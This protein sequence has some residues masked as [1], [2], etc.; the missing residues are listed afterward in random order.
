MVAVILTDNLSPFLFSRTINTCRCTAAG[1]GRS[2]T[3][4][5][6]GFF[7]QGGDSYREGSKNT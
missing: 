1:Q 6:N 2:W 4:G 7:W 3:K 5:C